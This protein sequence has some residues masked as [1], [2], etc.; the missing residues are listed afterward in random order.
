MDEDQCVVEHGI[1]E[2]KTWWWLMKD[3]NDDHKKVCHLN[4]A[5]ISDL[6]RPNAAI[7]HIESRTAY[8]KCADVFEFFFTKLFMIFSKKKE[9]WLE[10][11]LLLLLKC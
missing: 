2:R 10:L 4:R 9:I 11:L 3:R 5:E 6:Q 7:M 8:G 1:V